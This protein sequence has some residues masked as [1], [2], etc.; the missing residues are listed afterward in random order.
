MMHHDGNPHI[1]GDHESSFVWKGFGVVL[2]FFSP[3]INF[4]L[5]ERMHDTVIIVFKRSRTTTFCVGGGGY[6]VVEVHAVNR[7]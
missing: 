6:L 1:M 4:L 5:I 2:I 3:K 7:S